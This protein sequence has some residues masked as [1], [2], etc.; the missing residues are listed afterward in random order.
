MLSIKVGGNST[1]LFNPDVKYLNEHV[2]KQMY[3]WKKR[4]SEDFM[5]YLITYMHTSYIKT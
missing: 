1:L 2:N 4:T 5:H 3:V